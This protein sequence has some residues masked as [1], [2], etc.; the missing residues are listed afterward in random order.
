MVL[1][2]KIIVLKKLGAIDLVVDTA[3]K[4]ISGERWKGGDKEY[5]LLV[6]LDIKNA[7][8]T[9]RW[10]K[11]MEALEKMKVPGY[12][13]RMIVSYFSDRILR[14]DTEEGPKEYR[15]TGGVPQGSV[16]SPLLWNIMYDG[17]L[18][19]KLP[20]AVTLVAFA[21][22]IILD[23]TG[24]FLVDLKNLFSVSYQR[25]QDYLYYLGLELVKQKTEVVLGTGRKKLETITLQAGQHRITSQ[26]SIRYLGVMFD[27]RLNFKRHVEYVASKV[28]AVRSA[29][30]RLMPKGEGQDKV[31]NYS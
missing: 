20:R 1:N 21:D 25:Y 3:K 23:I 7:F 22:D 6:A 8:N 30:S 5:C 12:L 2:L 24:K 9:A 28:S 26:A 27:A 29:L 16:L 14:Y 15:V 4:A 13:R 10:D 18:R 17:L 11:I 19:V 31:E